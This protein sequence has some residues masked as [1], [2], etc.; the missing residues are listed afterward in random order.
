MLRIARQCRCFETISY[1]CLYISTNPFVLSA[2]IKIKRL[3]VRK[4]S[5]ANFPS[6]IILRYFHMYQSFGLVNQVSS[7]LKSKLSKKHNLVSISV[8]LFAKNEALLLEVPFSLWLHIRSQNQA[9]HSTALCYVLPF[10]LL[11]FPQKMLRD[12]RSR[13]TN[14]EVSYDFPDTLKSTG[15]LY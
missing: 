7:E 9:V 2:L 15:G 13:L 8:T 4:S 12:I 3:G 11:E 14:L 10:F 6:I 1:Q 5:L